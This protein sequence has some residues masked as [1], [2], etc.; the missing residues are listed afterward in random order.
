MITLLRGR[1]A[2][3][4]LLNLGPVAYVALVWYG[5]KMIS[6]AQRKLTNIQATSATRASDEQS[7]KDAA[8]RSAGN[9]DETD[10]NRPLRV[11]ALLLRR[12]F[13]TPGET[14]SGKR[15]RGW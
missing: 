14:G 7:Q 13:F 10:M 9:R 12:W 2:L 3:D 6:R 15:R 11:I 1:N 8:A 5:G 4:R